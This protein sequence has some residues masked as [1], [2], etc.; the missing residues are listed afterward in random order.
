MFYLPLANE[1]GVLSS[2]S[3]DG[4][5]DSKLSQNQ[6]FLEPEVTESLQEPMVSR[7]F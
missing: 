1:A 5:G 6:L 2:I 4:H 3:P 7:N